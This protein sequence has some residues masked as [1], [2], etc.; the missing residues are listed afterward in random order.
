MARISPVTL[1][2]SQTMRLH[3]LFKGAVYK[4]GVKQLVLPVPKYA[5]PAA[6]V[7]GVSAPTAPAR[8]CNED[9]RIGKDREPP[10]RLIRSSDR[11][12]TGEATQW[13]M[14]Q[15]MKVVVSRSAT[16]SS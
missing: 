5:G 15:P 2:T 11:T 10:V 14:R 16:E 4:E 12:S 9:E 3:R 13:T 7:G 1:R 8:G 6:H